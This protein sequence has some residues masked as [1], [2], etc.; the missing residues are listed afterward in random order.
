MKVKKKNMRVVKG[1]KC[2]K[3]LS[4]A[5]LQRN[6]SFYARKLSPNTRKYCKATK[7]SSVLIRTRSKVQ[8]EITGGSHA[9]QNSTVVTAG[10]PGCI[11]RFTPGWLSLRRDII[12]KFSEKRKEGKPP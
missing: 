7:W 4:F 8:G 12:P 6:F 10:F 5:E 1:I 9:P 3:F 11:V 2:N